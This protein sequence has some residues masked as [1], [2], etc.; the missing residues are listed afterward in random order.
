MQCI[1]NKILPNCVEFDSSLAN[2][3]YIYLRTLFAGLISRN[4]RAGVSSIMALAAA[5]A[6]KAAKN[7]AIFILG[8]IYGFLEGKEANDFDFAQVKVYIVVS[9]RA[10]ASL[11][12]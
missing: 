8:Q 4:S 3:M 6:T 12:Q 9:A 2:V 5:K 10:Y 11:A 7:N 1:F